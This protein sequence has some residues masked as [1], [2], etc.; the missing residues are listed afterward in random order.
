M[1]LVSFSSYV[2]FML[3]A[4][5]QQ[6][7]HINLDQDH[8]V[9]D[10]SLID[11]CLTPHLAVF[12]LMQINILG[13]RISLTIVS[14]L[15]RKITN[16]LLGLSFQLFHYE[17]ESRNASCALNQIST[18]VLLYSHALLT[19]CPFIFSVAI[20]TNSILSPNSLFNLHEYH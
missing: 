1:L 19:I 17:R 16:F 10:Q 4:H 20:I 15:N 18:F 3:K 12:H 11:R 6:S 8:Y 5:V 9:N 14:F 2:L 13:Q 7:N